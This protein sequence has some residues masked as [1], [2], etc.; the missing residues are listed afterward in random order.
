MGSMSFLATGPVPP[1]VEEILGK[2][3]P[4]Y[5]APASDEETLT[6]LMDGAVGLIVRGVTRISARVIDAGKQLRVIGRSGIGCD[7]VDL[8]AATARKIPV[9][10]T[11]GAPTTAVAEGAMAMIL[12]LAKRLPELDRRTKAGD[13]E[14]RDNIEIRDLE[15]ATLGVVGFGRIGRALAR[16]AYSFNMRLLAH[17]PYVGREASEPLGAE[18]VELDTL[19]ATSDFIAVVAPLT[20]ETR[21]MIDRR[22]LGLVK[23]GAILINLG[24]GAVLESLDTVYE[25]LQAKRLRAVGLDVFPQEPPDTSHPIFSHP[26]VLCTP[27]ALGLSLGARKKIF[28]MM[29]EGMAAILE[30]RIPENVINP[31]VFQKE[32]Q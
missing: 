20:E 25:A 18:L 17:D 3:G 16:R 21:G 9:I 26:D 1:I 10:Y 8:A 14:V 28:A 27:H 5:I 12:S 30:G 11:P 4:I 15:G 29:S 24:R 2:F 19:F 22:R 6:A 13:W 32:G 23:P 31:E 7:N